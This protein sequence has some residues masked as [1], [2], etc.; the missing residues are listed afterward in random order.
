MNSDN[1]TSNKDFSETVAWCDCFAYEFLFDIPVG[2][3]SMNSPK[4][5]KN[6]YSHTFH[7]SL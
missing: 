7:D 1:T 6:T 5:C 4:N 2:C 3:Q